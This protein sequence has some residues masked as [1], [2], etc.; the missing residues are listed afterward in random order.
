MDER[1]RGATDL[2]AALHRTGQA[3]RTYG[4]AQ[5]LAH[6]SV[7]WKFYGGTG[8]AVEP[9]A[10][11]G[12]SF[13]L[14][15]DLQRW[16][17]MDIGFRAR[18][19]GFIVEGDATVDDPLPGRGTSGN[20]RWLRDLPDVQTSDLDEAIEALERYAAELCAYESVLDDLGVPRT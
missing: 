4:Y 13:Q 14:G 20:Q 7:T 8:H 15:D 16:V 19:G 6:Q 12:V 5:F 18:D 1:A 10:T 11:V 9:F 17:S 2:L 3:F